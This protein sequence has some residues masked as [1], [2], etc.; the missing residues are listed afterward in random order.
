MSPAAQRAM[1][2]DSSE[3]ARVPAAAA[4]ERL[5]RFVA[6]LTGSSRSRISGAVERGEVLVD[7]EVAH[8][9]SERLRE[10]Q[11]VELT[12]HPDPTTPVPEPQPGIEFGVVHEDPSVIVVDKPSGLVVHPGPGHAGGTLCNGLLGRFPD[13]AEVGDPRRPGIVHRL[14]KMTSGLLVV[15]RSASAYDHLVEQLAHHRVERT[16]SAVVLGH[17]E[18]RHGVVDAPIGRSRRNPLRMTVAAGAKDSRTHFEVLE[19]FE[20]PP[21]ALMRCRL[22]TGRTH[23]IRVHMASIGHPVAGDDLYGGVRNGVGVSRIFLHAEGLGFVHPDSGEE[24]HFSSTL[25]TELA[26]WLAMLRG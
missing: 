3:V 9:G 12:F 1:D 26:D 24:V 2:P 23:Q 17:P 11:L 4:G 8:R 13:L 25:P 19:D 21:C 15:A 5:D 14:D 20:E 10:G 16:Y 7:G 6:L 22:E 18:A